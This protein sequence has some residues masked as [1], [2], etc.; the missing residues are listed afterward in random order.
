MIE[1]ESSRYNQNA[2]RRFSVSKVDDGP[3]RNHVLELDKVEG[4]FDPNRYD[5][6]WVEQGLP[7]GTT[8]R[9]EGSAICLTFPCWLFSYGDPKLKSEWQTDAP[10]PLLMAIWNALACTIQDELR[11][12]GD[13]R[14]S[15]SRTRVTIVDYRVRE[16]GSRP[17]PHSVWPMI[18]AVVQHGLMALAD[19]K[20]MTYASTWYKVAMRELERVEVWLE[21]APAESV[22]AE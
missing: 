16:G 5:P 3:L 14:E 19:P 7:E 12:D 8:V 15:P 18:H 20:R 6:S 4:W 13:G 2:G 22:D 10:D 17:I 1:N 21:Y 9:R 11:E